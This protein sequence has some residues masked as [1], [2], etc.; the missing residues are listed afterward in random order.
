MPVSP[1]SN[2]EPVRLASPADFIAVVPYLLGYHPADSLVAM[3]FDGDALKGV[4]R[5]DLPDCSEKAPDAATHC[6]RLLAQNAARNVFLIG[7]GSGQQV[8]P[9]MDGLHTA[10]TGAGMVVLDMVRCEGGRYWSYICHDPDCCSSDGVPYDVTSSL[11]AAGAVLAGCVAMPDRETF[12]RIVEP[13]DGPER[14]AIRTATVAARARAESMLDTADVEYWF[15]EGTR[16]IRACLDDVQAGRPIPVEDLAWLGV[17]LTGTLVRDIAMTFH[18]EYGDDVSHRFWIEVVRRLEPEYLPA[19]AVNLAFLAYRSGD[20]TLARLAA[21]RALQ[22]DPNYRFAKM[23][24]F[25]LNAGLPPTGILD[26]DF[27]DLAEAIT[28]QAMRAPRG[29]RPI[30]PE[31]LP[32]N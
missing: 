9:L 30:L 8:T 21:E 15:R 10:I 4:I 14:Q 13:V 1:D 3:A 32:E 18:R 20:G 24:L 7:Y 29:A 25:A 27:A 23:I 22:V 28:E 12:A 17:L 5:F 31:T 19:P 11:A 2:S 16:H 26:I 6:A